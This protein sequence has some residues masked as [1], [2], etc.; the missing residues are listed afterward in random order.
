MDKV[1][2]ELYFTIVKAK[3]IHRVK[4]LLYTLQVIQSQNDLLK[5]LI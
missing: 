1:F 5:V 3:S 2:W 4:Y